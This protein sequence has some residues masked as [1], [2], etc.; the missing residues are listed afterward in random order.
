MALFRVAPEMPSRELSSACSGD[1]RSR[2]RRRDVVWAHVCPARLD[3][4]PINSSFNTTSRVPDAISIIIQAILLLPPRPDRHCVPWSS[5]SR[6]GLVGAK[7]WHWRGSE[8]RDRLRVFGLPDRR[9]NAFL[10]LLERN[11]RF[12]CL[13]PAAALLVEI[14]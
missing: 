4:Y 7:R 5:L 8:P 11:C 13:I 2:G 10:F 12:I 14:E 9:P 6:V 1:C 3:L